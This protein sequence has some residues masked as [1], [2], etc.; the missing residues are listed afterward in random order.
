MIEMILYKLL[1]Q[2]IFFYFYLILEFCFLIV[3]GMQL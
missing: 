1:L 2:K 3:S